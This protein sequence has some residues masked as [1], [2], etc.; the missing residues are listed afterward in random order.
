METRYQ[1]EYK[2]TRLNTSWPQT[3][4]TPLDVEKINTSTS[5]MTYYMP[6]PEAGRTASTFQRYGVHGNTLRKVFIN[7]IP[8]QSDTIKT[9][10]PR[11]T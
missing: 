10:Q 5:C 2:T 8:Y 1:T 3:P 6:P 4:T 7:E 9:Y 11:Q